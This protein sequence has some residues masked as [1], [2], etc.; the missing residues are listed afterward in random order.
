MR[1]TAIVP[2]RGGSKGIKG[3]NLAVVD[4]VPLVIKALET[5][6]MLSISGHEVNLFCSTEDDQITRVVEAHGYR[7]NARP[8][9]LAT[10]DATIDQVVEYYQSFL[11]AT[12]EVLLIHQPTV[13]PYFDLN[14]FITKFMALSE[15]K[16]ATVGAR[17]DHIIWRETEFGS[18]MRVTPRENRQAQKG[19][20]REIGI[21]AYRL[22]APSYPETIIPMTGGAIDIDTPSD[23]LLA[24]HIPGWITFRVRANADVGYGHLHRCLAIASHLQH[25]IV[26]FL[27]TLDSDLGAIESTKSV[28]WPGGWES[29]DVGRGVLINDTLDTTPYEMATLRSKYSHIITLEDMGKGAYIADQAIDSLYKPDGL[30]YAVLRPEFIGL[31]TYEVRPNGRAVLVSFGGT[32][33]SGLTAKLIRLANENDWADWRFVVPPGL[34]DSLPETHFP[35][36]A[37]PSMAYEMRHADL[38]ITSAGRTVYEAMAVGVPTITMAANPREAHHAHLGPSYGNLYFGMGRLVVPEDLAQ[39]VAVTLSDVILRRQLSAAGRGRVDAQG[40]QRIARLVEQALG[41]ERE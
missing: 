23:L 14:V 39:T 1:I 21:R 33:P 35:V 12:Y 38:L 22:G 19:V 9:D 32:D 25:H 20:Y 28:G 11:G 26:V 4:S 15:E 3:K 34:R 29:R 41:E 31:P 10:D 16:S 40:A 30:K 27:F 6:K 24:R 8:A 7:A 17:S 2:A 36:I 18:M 5:C 37:N 13:I